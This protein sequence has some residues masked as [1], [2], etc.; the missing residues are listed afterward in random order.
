MAASRSNVRPRHRAEYA[1]LF[2]RLLRPGDTLVDLGAHLRWISLIGAK[3]VGATGKVVAVDPQPYNC[4]RIL[5]NAEL[6]GFDQLTVV[7]VVLSEAPIPIQQ[8]I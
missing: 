6:N 3:A 5:A 8:T 4:D 1:G 2:E 7:A